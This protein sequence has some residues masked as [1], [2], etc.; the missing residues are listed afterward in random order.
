MMT[1]ALAAEALAQVHAAETLL[2]A[3]PTALAGKHWRRA[4]LALG[5]AED[6][7]EEGRRALEGA[8]L[9]DDSEAVRV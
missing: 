8:R 3:H 6:A 1:L 2:L 5:Y 4:L 9:E 7:L